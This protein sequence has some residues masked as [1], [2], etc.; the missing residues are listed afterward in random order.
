MTAIDAHTSAASAAAC[1]KDH[2]LAEFERE[3]D[4]VQEFG[5]SHGAPTGKGCQSE[6]TPCVDRLPAV[7]EAFETMAIEEMALCLRGY[8][9]S[10]ISG[11]LSR[12]QSA[13]KLKDILDLQEAAKAADAG[14]PPRSLLAD[15]SEGPPRSRPSTA[16]SSSS[17]CASMRTS[18]MTTRTIV[19]FE[20]NRSAK[21]NGSESDDDSIQREAYAER[22]ECVQDLPAM[23]DVLKE[24]AV[25]EI[26]ECLRGRSP[27]DIESVLKGMRFPPS[28]EEVMHFQAC[29]T[30]FDA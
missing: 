22:A 9:P 16:A 4:S 2:F 26:A 20:S 21:S 29:S 13:P 7:A 11:V 8:P 18:S 10:L 27:E 17:S 6:R 1:R 5:F 25:S 24:S 28:L 15:A 12:M 14:C 19:K 3:E 30:D 23:C